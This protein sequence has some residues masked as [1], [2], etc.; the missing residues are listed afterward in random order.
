[1]NQK[2]FFHGVL[3]DLQH[4]ISADFSLYHQDDRNHS[5][6]LYLQHECFQILQL[7]TAC[8]AAA[9]ICA[10]EKK[11]VQAQEENMEA[12]KRIRQLHKRKMEGSDQMFHSAISSELCEIDE[13]KREK[14][15][16]RREYEAEQQQLRADKH[17]L[18]NELEVLRVH[19]SEQEEQKVTL[20]KR[21]QRLQK[22]LTESQ[23]ESGRLRRQ[24]E[25]R[26]TASQTE[27]AALQEGLTAFETES[28]ALQERLTAS[29]TESDNMQERLTTALAELQ[30]VS[31]REYHYSVERPTQ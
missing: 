28:A 25:E 23:A 7:G 15:R 16:G 30:V 26:L 17:T 29:Q 9:K 4:Y 24:F 31:Q 6:N 1:M 19:S 3:Y 22:R 18:E 21:N 11:V 2:T 10:L 13:I 5:M 27:S 8:S 12:M 20:E 14:E